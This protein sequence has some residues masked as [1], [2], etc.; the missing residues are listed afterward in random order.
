MIHKQEADIM[1]S[2]NAQVKALH[3]M[4]CNLDQQ[5]RIQYIK[6]MLPQLLS[7]PRP[8]QSAREKLEEQLRKEAQPLSESELDIINE[9]AEKTERLYRA[10]NDEETF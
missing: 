9:M 6:V 1:Q 2:L 7:F 10:M 3:N 8:V 5:E 4:L